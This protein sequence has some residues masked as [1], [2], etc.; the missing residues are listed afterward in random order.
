VS[1]L[2]LGLVWLGA[3]AGCAPST[4]TPEPAASAD[5]L[6]AAALDAP[7]RLSLPLSPA[8][9]GELVLERTRQER[10]EL[11]PPVTVMPSAPPEIAP[12]LPGAEPAPPPE[13]GLE[14]VHTTTED[15][16]LKPPIPRGLP[17]L[18]RGGR[19]GRVALDVRVDEQ[20]EV[21]DAELVETDAD[22]ATVAAAIEAAY[23][24]RFY[25]AILGERRV[26]VWTRQSFQVKRGR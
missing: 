19:G 23:S 3:H 18:P 20:G 6:P 4:R 10:A 9:S 17:V 24:L 13:G 1:A 15:P 25:P 8:G 21:T 22:S 2:V 5:T 12:S 7:E 26:A 14:R 16:A 11:P